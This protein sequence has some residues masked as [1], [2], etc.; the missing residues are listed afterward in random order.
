MPGTDGRAVLETI[1]SDIIL[2]SIPV[3]ILTTSSDEND[4]KGC[5]Q[6]GANSYLQKPVDF[7]EF[8]SS[9]KCLKEYWFDISILPC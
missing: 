7:Q 4:V 9:I 8:I 2:R 3:V 5:Y 1:K 6:S